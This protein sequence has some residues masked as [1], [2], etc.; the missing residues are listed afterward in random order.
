LGGGYSKKTIPFKLR[1][2]TGT[3]NA[4]INRQNKP[5]HKHDHITRLKHTLILMAN[6]SVALILLCATLSA[7]L[8]ATRYFN[9]LAPTQS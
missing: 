2:K 8:S 9:A 7:F 3:F 6:Y 5:N 1:R 4:V